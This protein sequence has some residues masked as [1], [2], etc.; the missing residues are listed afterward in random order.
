M[1]KIEADK[2]IGISILAGFEIS[3]AAF[4]AVLLGVLALWPEALSAAGTNIRLL[5]SLA[6]NHVVTPSSNLGG[7]SLGMKF[8]FPLYILKGVVFGA[9]LLMMKSW[10]RI[11]LMWLSGIYLSDTCKL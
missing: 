6:T 10:A 4:L 9:G 3:K 1:R 7:G 11:V 2:A 8:I 5:I